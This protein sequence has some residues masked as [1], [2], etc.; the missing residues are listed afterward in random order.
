MSV[1][2]RYDLNDF[3]LTDMVD[4]GARLRALAEEAGS[5]E[6]AAQ[7]VVQFLY[8]TLASAEAGPSCALIRCFITQPLSKLPRD[9]A[10]EARGALVDSAYTEASVRCLALMASAGML[11]Q[12]N[13]RRES[14]GHRVIPLESRAK[15]EGA[16]MIA[17]LLS[18]MGLDLDVFLDTAKEFRLQSEEAGFGLFYVAAAE[19]SPFVPAQEFVRELEVKSVMGFGGWLPAGDIFAIL[20]FTRIPVD[21][22]VA[23][24]FRT[25]A[26]SAKLALLP[27][28]SG[29]IFQGDGH[30]LPPAEQTRLE[31][32]RLRTAV[33]TMGHILDGLEHVASRSMSELKLAL[34]KVQDAGRLR[35]A[36]SAGSIG[37]WEFDVAGGQLLWDEQMYRLFGV[38]LDLVKTPWEIWDEATMAEEN[39][40][41]R[42]ERKK[43][44]AGGGDL[45]TETQVRWPDGTIHDVRVLGAMQMDANEKPRGI[46]GTIWDVTEER[47]VSSRLLEVNRELQRAITRADEANASKSAFLA[48]MSHEIRTPMNGV[49]GMLQMMKQSD[50][51]DDNRHFLKVAEDSG[52]ILLSLINDILDLSKIEAGML[53]VE[54]VEFDLLDCI[55]EAAQAYQYQAEE[56][57]VSFN[58]EGSPRLPQFVIGDPLRLR[59]VLNNLCSNAIKFTAEGEVRLEIAQTGLQNGMSMLRFHVT[60]T[61]IGIPQ[62]RASSLFS[63]FVQVDSTTTR[64]FGGSGLGLAICKQLVGLMAGDIGFESEAGKGSTFWFTIAVKSAREPVR[65]KRPLVP[66]PMAP[67]MPSAPGVAAISSTVVPASVHYRARILVADDNWTNGQV[68]LAQLKKL[69]YAVEVVTDGA[70]AV[71]RITTGKFDLVL[72]DCEMPIMDGYTATAKIRD[73]IHANIPIVA[74]TAHASVADRDRC[75]QS[76]MDDFISKPV[77][78]RMLEQMLVKWLAKSGVGSEI[79]ED[80]QRGSLSDRTSFDQGDLLERLM[81]DKESA[82][83]IVSHFLEQL[84]GQTAKLQADVEQNNLASAQRQAHS[85]KGAASSISAKKLSSIAAEIET[86]AQA[87]ESGQLNGLLESFRL[88][89]KHLHHVA[90][91]LSWV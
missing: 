17:R 26:L 91:N 61:G 4:C 29:P 46:V 21:I 67:A 65:S 49:L 59:Q 12:W 78:V 38:P 16:P 90:E 48:N 64:K 37:V 75:L 30:A 68:A 2:T 7:R 8:S 86:A 40:R 5:M 20:L 63:P 85:L 45:N 41:L 1:E 88:E 69:G 42:Q 76:G 79:L 31:R 34:T 89:S 11:P 13:D 53:E 35:A 54:S 36:A 14:K 32:D 80:G 10:D 6:E 74:V 47:L 39:L 24:M 72:M 66:R 51:S 43:C 44:L 83:T 15:V 73:S 28:A 18:E 57:G 52:L 33:S 82:S 77:D 71:E 22:R 25:I 70:Q 60:D 58:W 3:D 50:L 81:G 27:F 23:D 56:K 19:G 87:G 9:L 55:N 62:E 84:H